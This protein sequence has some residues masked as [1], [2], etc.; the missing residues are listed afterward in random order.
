MKLYA[1]SELAKDI[2]ETVDN[3]GRALESCKDRAGKGD[4]LYDGIVATEKILLKTLEKYG[5]VLV[6]PLK[7]K[8]DPNLHEALM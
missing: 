3:L 8:F 5:V 1:V 6:N 7:E 4:N 2:L